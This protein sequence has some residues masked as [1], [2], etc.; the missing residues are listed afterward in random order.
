[1]N[2]L[3]FRA[4]MMKHGDKVNDLAKYLNLHPRTLYYK[5][6]GKCNRAAFT[7]DE[8]KKIMERYKLTPEEV[9]RIFLS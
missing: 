8:I 3:E 2:T 7:L 4:Q 6:S 5:Y 1:M 9:V